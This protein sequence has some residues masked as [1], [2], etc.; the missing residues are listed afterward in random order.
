MYQTTFFAKTFV[1]PD[2]QLVEMFHCVR[3]GKHQ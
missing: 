2:I 3:M 1:I